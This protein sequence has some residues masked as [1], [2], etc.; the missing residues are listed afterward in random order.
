MWEILSRYGDEFH[1]QEAE[2]R[3]WRINK[4]GGIPSR[5]APRLTGLREEV[6]ERRYTLVLELTSPKI[7]YH[8]W[9]ERLSNY[10][11]FFGPNISARL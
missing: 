3:I 5:F 4:K 2:D 9:A 7:P 11:T 1:L 10:E 6:L 8:V